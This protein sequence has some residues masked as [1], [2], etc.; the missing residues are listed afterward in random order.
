MI[1]LIKQ[2]R[3]EDVDV[4][5]I[6]KFEWDEDKNRINRL[7]HGIDFNTA[8]HV[9]DD[10]NRIEIYDYEHSI[11]EDRYNTIGLVHDILFVVYTERKDSLRIISARL[12]T[13]AERRL[14][15]DG[16]SDI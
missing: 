10:E 3:K 11:D 12:A 9:F 8:I 6:L 1:K 13:A 16:Y 5:D 15:Y 14:Y 7:K 2:S 4:N